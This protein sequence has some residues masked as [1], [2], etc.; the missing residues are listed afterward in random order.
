MRNVTVPVLAAGLLALAA[1][2]F[3]QPPRPGFG[4]MQPNAAMLLRNEKVQDELKLSDDQKADL[5]KV[6]DRYG[7][8]IR[9]AFMDMDFKKAQ[10]LIKTAGD[11][12]EKVLKPDQTKRLKQI[13]LQAS[14]LGAFEKEDVQTALK[15][16]DKQ[17]KD[18]ADQKEEIEKD[19]KDLGE[20]AKGD[21]EK[22]REVFTKVRAMRNDAMTKVLDSFS[23]E[24][25]KAWKEMTGEKFEVEFAPPRRPGVGQ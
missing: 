11:E 1:P 22:M 5:K 20:N 3:A 17:K 21:R 9:K 10:E 19:A 6:G 13:E 16:T 25:K 12:A 2:A 23:D 15:L 14:G 8:D 4:M 7:D 24:Q 18:I